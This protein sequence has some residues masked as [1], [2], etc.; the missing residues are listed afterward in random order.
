[1]R[2]PTKANDEIFI[3]AAPGT[4]MRKRFDAAGVLAGLTAFGTA[5]VAAAAMARQAQNLRSLYTTSAGRI[6]LLKETIGKLSK[7]VPGSAIPNLPKGW[8]R[9]GRN[10]GDFLL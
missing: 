2:A 7:S 6:R 9:A 8:D 3:A 1:M 4:L 5:G 10:P